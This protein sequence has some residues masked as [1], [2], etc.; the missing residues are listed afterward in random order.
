MIADAAP[1]D[2]RGVRG[3]ASPGAE[4]APG[5][6]PAPAAHDHRRHPRPL[7]RRARAATRRRA[8]HVPAPAAARHAGGE[9]ATAGM[10]IPPSRRPRHFAPGRVSR[11]LHRRRAGVLAAMGA[12]TVAGVAL[13]LGGV[14]L[15]RSSTAG[16]YV[17]PSAGPD[18][19]GYQAYVVPTPTLAVVH[20]GEDG[21][22]A[23]ITLLALDA[24]DEG[25]AVVLVPPTTSVAFGDEHITI[26]GAFRSGGAE[27]AVDA[28]EAVLAADIAETVVVDD[29]RWASLVEPVAPV[30]V[31]VPAV[32][33]GFDAGEVELAPGDVGRFLAML[34]DR[35]TDLDRLDRTAR[36]WSAWVAEVAAGGDDAV[37]GEVEVGIGRFVRA[38][39]AG[40]I[41]TVALPVNEERDGDEV[42]YLPDGDRVAGLIGWTI[43]YPVSPAPGARVRVRLLNGTTDEGLTAAAARRLVGSGAEITIVGNGPSF[44]EPTTRLIHRLPDQRD[45][46]ERLAG[47]L[48]VGEVE[49]EQT[50]RGGFV[51]PD[52]EVDVTVILGADSRDRIEG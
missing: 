44:D 36:F 9:R 17:E 33:D 52:E 35:E 26:D 29:E 13:A 11:R 39:A 22:L 49:Q 28:V 30:R 12:L 21:S 6:D 31:E 32:V 51:V 25:G 45:D 14:S 1:G 2:R 23:G 40:D 42:R 38:F 48:G 24:G 10:A 41:T 27:G 46:A 4:P 37:P 8:N 15:V 43:P 50:P 34:G 5:G 18:E 19:P 20:P 16:R 3:P 7:S 47:D